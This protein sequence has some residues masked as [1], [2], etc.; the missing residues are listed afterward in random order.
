MSTK[1]KKNTPILGLVKKDQP[2]KPN[3]PKVKAKAKKRSPTAPT[4]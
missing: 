4:I 2:T 3:N 1:E